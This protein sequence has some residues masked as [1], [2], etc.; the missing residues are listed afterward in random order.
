MKR[1]KNVIIEIIIMFLFLI[2]LFPFFIVIINSSK[3]VFAITANPL[4]LP[5]KWV[6]IFKNIVEIWSNR[7]INYQMS[8]VSSIIITTI[9]L[10]LIAI[11]SSQGAWVLV[12]TKTRLSK[13]VFFIFIAAMVFPFQIVMLP[14]ISWFRTIHNVLGIRLLRTYKGLIFSYLAFGAPLSV[15]LYHGFIKGI[16]LELEEAAY[17]D[18]AS[19]IQIYYSIVF[20]ILRPVHA[21]VIVL[22][23]LWIWNDF[24]LPLLLLGLSNE[25]Q[26]LPLA[27]TLFV[28]TYIK[29]WDLIMTAILMAM[30]PIIILFLIAQRSIVKGMVAGAVKG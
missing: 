5:E 9:S 25:V 18:G 27:V 11:F 2:F 30:V 23:G 8:F 3:D 21:T 13:I 12:R 20:P 6:L 14:I 7:N 15:F 28:G 29:S 17:I 1:K 19:K 26:T 10:V 24:L 22:N 4:A 16:P